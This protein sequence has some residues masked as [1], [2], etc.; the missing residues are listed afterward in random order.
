MESGDRVEIGMI[1]VVWW[2]GCN[3]EGR[4]D[5]IVLREVLGAVASLVTRSRRKSE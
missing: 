5:G 1:G 3:M 4:I 2:G